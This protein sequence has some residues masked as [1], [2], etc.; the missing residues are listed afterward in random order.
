MRHGKF[1]AMWTALLLLMTVI[2]P[3]PSAFAASEMRLQITFDEGYDAKQGYVGVQIN[4][5]GEWISFSK[6]TEQTV[7]EEVTALAFRVVANEYYEVNFDNGPLLDYTG[8]GVAFHAGDAEE[9]RA[10]LI[11]E[12]GYRIEST[13]GFEEVSLSGIAFRETSA[14]RTA[15]LSISIEG[16]DLEYWEEDIPSRITLRFPGVEGDIE[17]GRNNLSWKDGNTP[18]N[19]TGVSTINPVSVTYDYDGSGEVQIEYVISNASTKITS[20]KVNKTDYTSFCPQS[21][22][23]IFANIEDGARSTKLVAIKVPYAESYEVEIKAEAHD[24][25]GGFGWNCLPEETLDGDSREDCIA[26]GTLTFIKGEYNGETYNSVSEWNEATAYGA[27]VFSWHDANRNYSDE[28]EAWGEAAFPKGAKITMKLIPD[29]GYQ[30]T[31]LYGDENIEPQEET[32]VY[33]ITMNG[34][35]N[36]HLSAI[37]DQIGDLVSVTADSVKGGSIANVENT[38]GEGT[39]KLGVDN[40]EI[41]GESREGF[42]AK[43][44]EESVEISDYMDIHLDNTIYKASEDADESWDRPVS[45]L[46]SD[47]TITLELSEDHSGE[48]LVIIHENGDSY[49]LIEANYNE[50]ENSLTFETRSFSN[51]ALAVRNTSQSNQYKITVDTHEQGT[52]DAPDLM[53]AG[54]TMIFITVKPNQGYVF[55]DCQAEGIEEG[56]EG[57]TYSIL[58]SGW[59][60]IGIL[61]HQMPENDIVFDIHFAEAVTVTWDANGGTTGEVWRDESVYKKGIE[62]EV[63]GLYNEEIVCAPEGTE[64]D[65][66]S[67]NGI[68][69]GPEDTLVLEEDCVIIYQWK[70]MDESEE[71]ICYAQMDIGEASKTDD[72]P[73]GWDGVLEFVQGETQTVPEEE[74]VLSMVIPPACKKYGGFEFDGIVYAPGAEFT[75]PNEEKIVIKIVWL[76]AHDWDEWEVVTEPTETETGLK[77]RVCKNNT[78]HI[79]TEILP[80]LEKEETSTDPAVS[81]TPVNT[82]DDAQQSENN[83][84]GNRLWSIALPLALVILPVLYILRRKV[85]R[86]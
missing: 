81:Y 43:A 27:H 79:E 39:M 5:S 57:E 35:M 23:E 67:V 74:D 29:E 55:D 49:E 25:M 1:F 44:R 36:S 50:E 76:D 77:R 83:Q 72:W 31:S 46:T 28:S 73:E 47:A 15:S 13:A 54:E 14:K 65:G 41:S 33:T 22:E 75:V 82:K 10:A 19:A 69:Y 59:P 2:L 12:D 24:L 71:E 3:G 21:D 85:K 64:F 62:M 6:S 51:Y 58:Y 60:E 84:A 78:T 61:I 7:S 38:Y 45:E 4:D 53:D 42:E 70:E 11:G 9:K 18:P 40:A 17:F 30:L 52:A 20:F 37:F 86:A 80:K 68:F 32:G 63:S 26:H 66:V 16:A 8:G 56:E 48:D 34:G